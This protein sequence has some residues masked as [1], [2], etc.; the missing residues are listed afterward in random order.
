M[1]ALESYQFLL[2]IETGF[3]VVVGLMNTIRKLQR[4]DMENY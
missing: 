1:S 3:V 4:D 2:R